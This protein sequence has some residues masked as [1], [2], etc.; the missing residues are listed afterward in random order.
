MFVTLSSQ[1]TVGSYADGVRVMPTFD[2]ENRVTVRLSINEVAQMLEVF[3]G[4][5]ESICDGK[6]LFHKTVKA[7]TVITL[8]HRLEPAPGYLFSVSRKAVD[9][10]LRR[11]SILVSMTEALVL[12][13]A[14]AASMVYMAFGVPSVLARERKPIQKEDGA[15]ALKEVA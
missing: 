13:E 11:M 5:H 8:E 6:G 15:A 9:G 12:C 3:R 14:L 10:N 7:S 4:Y 2:W 1:K